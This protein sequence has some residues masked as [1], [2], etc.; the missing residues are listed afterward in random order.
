MKSALPILLGVGAVA[1][2]ASRKKK[3]KSRTSDY[4]FEDEDIIGMQEL[5]VSEVPKIGPREVGFSVDLSQSRI[6]ATWRIN[7]LDAWLEKRR[8]AGK[9]ATVDHDAGYLYRLFIDDP[10]TFLGDITQ[11]GKTGGTIIYGALWLM[12]TVGVGIYAAGAGSYTLGQ[13]AHF[14]G[15]RSLW[16]TRTFKMLAHQVART[17]AGVATAQR[18]GAQNVSHLLKTIADFGGKE[19]LTRF[20]VSKAVSGLSAGAVMAGGGMSLHA[21]AEI[22]VD[23]AFAP[24]LAASATE[25]AAEFM[26]THSVNAGGVQI[27]ISLLPSSDEFPKVQEFNKIII[28]YILGF[29]KRHFEY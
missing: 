10:T 5:G 27:P 19:W 6:G 16:A 28:G 25:N 8:R 1:V 26:A 20:G 24:D 2:L 21:L 17:E 22:G 13:A 29:Q 11:T 9:L 7:I 14:A 18:A 12:A 4:V 23:E 15:A 3:A